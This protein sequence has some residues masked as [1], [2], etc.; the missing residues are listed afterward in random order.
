MPESVSKNLKKV[1]QI[2]EGPGPRCM[3]SLS[4]E[5]SSKTAD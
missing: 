3:D 2:D 1:I 4:V 5:L